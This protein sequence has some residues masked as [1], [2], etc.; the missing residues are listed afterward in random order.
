MK[1][2]YTKV[3]EHAEARG[4]VRICKNPSD[5]AA[6]DMLMIVAMT[7][8]VPLAAA[9]GWCCYKW[10]QSIAFSITFPAIPVP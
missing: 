10:H 8:I 4:G 9:L 2:T 6:S 5:A 7:V 3:F 1:D